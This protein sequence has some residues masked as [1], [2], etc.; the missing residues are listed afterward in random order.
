MEVIK[1]ML[2]LGLFSVFGWVLGEYLVLRK[3]Y[4]CLIFRLRK[5]ERDVD[6]D[7]RRLKL[8]FGGIGLS[9]GV[10]GELEI[11]GNYRFRAERRAEVLGESKTKDTKKAGEV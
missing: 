5:M 6:K 3:E 8:Q 1:I 9:K 10:N 7:I 4:R 2:V 11:S